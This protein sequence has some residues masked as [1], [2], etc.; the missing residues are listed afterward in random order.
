MMADREEEEKISSGRLVAVSQ[1]SYTP[2]HYR[3]SVAWSDEDNGF[4]GR[5]EEFPFLSAVQDTAQEAL[6]D[7]IIVVT[8]CLCLM[9]SEGKDVPAPLLYRRSEEGS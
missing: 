9:E 3:Y 1:V 7:I 8:T 6:T 2:T 5:C 4:V